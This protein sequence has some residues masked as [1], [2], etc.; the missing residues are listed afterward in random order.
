MKENPQRKRERRNMRRADK[1]WEK[2]ADSRRLWRKSAN[3]L[4][5]AFD[6]TT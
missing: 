2:S 5:G 3:A 6:E 4:N 1:R